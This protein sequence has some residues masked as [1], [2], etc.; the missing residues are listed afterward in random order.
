MIYFN[1]YLCFLTLRNETQFDLC[2][3]LFLHL[4]NFRKLN[5]K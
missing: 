3:I 4:A 5:L 2:I 1:E